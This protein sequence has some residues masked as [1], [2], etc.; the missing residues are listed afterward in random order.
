MGKNN[1][2][3]GKIFKKIKIN[4]KKSLFPK[5]SVFRKKLIFYSKPKPNSRDDQT[6][7]LFNFI[8]KHPTQNNNFTFE[9]IQENK[10]GTKI[11]LNKC[12]NP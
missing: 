12:I 8:K 4:R 11:M 10:E 6:Q 9:L 2:K 3:N 7:K 1:S 5:I